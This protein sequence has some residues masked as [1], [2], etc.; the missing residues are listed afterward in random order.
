MFPAA[1]CVRKD[2]KNDAPE[3]ISPGC[4][5]L[6]E[7]LADGWWALSSH[8]CLAL[9]LGVPSA[10][11]LG[12]AGV[13]P[14]HRYYGP[15]RQA[16]AFLRLRLAA[17]RS[18]LLRSLSPRG[19]GPF[20]GFCSM[21]LCACRRLYPAGC[22]GARGPFRTVLLPSPV[23]W[24]LGTRIS[25]LTRPQ[26]AFIIVTACVLAHPTEIGLCQWPSTQP[27]YPDRVPLKLC[28]VDLLPR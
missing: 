27:G 2:L 13:T 15:D 24:R 20:S 3:R 11:P 6:L 23:I 21:A 9:L 1:R 5:S 8:A 14:L 22:H 26:S 17:R 18:T 10:G 7:V 4:L 28:G 12:S 19:A 25:F 16:C